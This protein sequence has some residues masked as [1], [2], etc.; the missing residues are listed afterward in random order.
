ME[1]SLGFKAAASSDVDVGMAGNSSPACERSRSQKERIARP[2]RRYK[3]R[4]EAALA[5][6]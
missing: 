2:V 5:F 6:R 3:A 4:L 1:T